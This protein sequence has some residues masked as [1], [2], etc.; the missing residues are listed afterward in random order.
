[1]EFIYVVY[2][3]TSLACYQSVK[4]F[5]AEQEARD[6]CEMQNQLNKPES[7][8]WGYVEGIN[9]GYYKLELI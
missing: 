1:M 8:D 3:Q 2:Q 5:K 4:A 7:D 6:Y 9:H